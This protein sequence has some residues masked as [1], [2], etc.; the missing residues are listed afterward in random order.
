MLCVLEVGK[1]RGG[2][3]IVQAIGVCHVRTLKNRKPHG[4]RVV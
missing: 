4:K 1:D 3:Y 2:T